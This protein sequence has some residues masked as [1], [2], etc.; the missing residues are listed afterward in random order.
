MRKRD[1]KD[2]SKDISVINSVYT[3]LWFISLFVVLRKKKE[4]I[5]EVWVF[6]ET[7]HV[8]V[9]SRNNFSSWASLDRTTAWDGTSSLNEHSVIYLV[10]N[11]G[12]K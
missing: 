11:R 8:N 4:T 9:L 10:D 1:V 7:E 2:Y 6:K 12:L 5:F 3:L